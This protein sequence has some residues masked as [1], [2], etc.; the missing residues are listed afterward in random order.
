MSCT[1]RGAASCSI[2]LSFTS[3]FHKHHQGLARPRKS[4]SARLPSPTHLAQQTPAIIVRLLQ[5]LVHRQRHGLKGRVP[6]DPAG[7]T[8]KQHNQ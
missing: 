6:G 4:C 1:L 3:E 5:P 8:H 2:F 7:G